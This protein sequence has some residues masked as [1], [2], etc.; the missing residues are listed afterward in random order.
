VRERLRRKE[1]ELCGAAD[2]FRDAQCAELDTLL[3]AARDKAEQ[4][5][6]AAE[7]V[8]ARVAGDEPVSLLTYYAEHRAEMEELAALRVP[9][10]E[11]PQA[12]A[13][14]CFLNMDAT[15]AQIEALNG[16]HLII[17]TLKADDAEPSMGG[18]GMGGGGGPHRQ[19]G[20]RVG[21]RS[22]TA[23]GGYAHP[24]GAGAGAGVGGAS[25]VR[26]ADQHR[27]LGHPS[28]AMSP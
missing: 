7:I 24:F 15:N 23:R 12:A 9:V 11:L 8:R 25:V 26:H 27:A 4:I 18:G 19:S 1:A 6:V 20:S 14:K 16:L 13:R 10:P 17:A 5:D 2:A 22:S 28:Y 21:S 3:R